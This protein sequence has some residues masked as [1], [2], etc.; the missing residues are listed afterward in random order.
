MMYSADS[1]LKV[2]FLNDKPERLQQYL[3]VY[4]LVV[5]DDPDFSVPLGLVNDI[6]AEGVTSGDDQA[7]P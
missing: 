5:L 7:E 4:D 1:L 3:E 6:C 2:G